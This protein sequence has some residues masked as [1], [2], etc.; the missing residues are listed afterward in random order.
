MLRF[1]QHDWLRNR[2]PCHAERS[3][4]ESKHLLPKM[5][6]CNISQYNWSSQNAFFALRL[7]YLPWRSSLRV[8]STLR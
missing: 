2:L 3:E 5:P 4:A 1:A 7:Q 8:Y 6:M